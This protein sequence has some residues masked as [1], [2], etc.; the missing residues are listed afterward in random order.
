VFSE[1]FGIPPTTGTDVEGTE[2]FPIFLQD[3]TTEEFSD[4]LFWIYKM[5]DSQFII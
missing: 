2:M 1:I 5:C 4:L 3:V